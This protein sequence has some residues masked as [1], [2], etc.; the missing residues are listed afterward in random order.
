VAISG[1][2]IEYAACSG[3]T[4]QQ[5]QQCLAALGLE[6]T[7]YVAGADSTVQFST[8]M[9]RAAEMPERARQRLAAAAEVVR[10]F[11]SDNLVSMAGPWL[12]EVGAGGEPPPAT[13]IRDSGDEDRRVGH[14]IDAAI[15]WV[16]G[17]PARAARR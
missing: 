3:V 13:A 2:T 1:V 9:E 14:L 10:V 7:A 8:W 12:R 11:A 5:V 6:L 16:A 15:A 4:D 17:R